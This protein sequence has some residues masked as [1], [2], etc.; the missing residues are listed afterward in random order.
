MKGRTGGT[1][2]AITMRGILGL[3]VLLLLGA[4]AAGTAAAEDR[5]ARIATL[6]WPP[7]T[8]Q[9]LREGGATTKV[10]RTAFAAAGYEVE[11]V[12]ETWPIAIE[13]ARKGIGGVVAYYPGYHCRHREGF[14]ASDPV[15]RSP[16]GFAEHVDSPLVWQSLDDIGD[17]KLKI[18]TV[19]GYTNTDEFDAKVGMGWIRAIPSDNDAENL[20][21]LL[22]RRID[23]AVVDKHVLAFLARTDDRLKGGLESLRFN[24]K[25]LEEKTFHLCFRDDPEAVRLMRAF[26]EGLASVAVDSMVESYV[27]GALPE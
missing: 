8:G 22:R 15:G 23:A 11:V 19:R 9:G 26:N 3:A 25:P 4:G 18:G 24:D 14:V 21:K 10:I 6:E 27:T 5:V 12:Y 1:A 17:R 7:Y 20:D 13:T 16:L 2:L